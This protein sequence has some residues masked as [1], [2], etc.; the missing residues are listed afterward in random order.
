MKKQLEQLKKLS[1]ELDA[2]NWQ[3]KAKIE[4]FHKLAYAVNV[5]LEDYLNQ[6]AAVGLLSVYAW[7]GENRFVGFEADNA[8]LNGVGLQIDCKLDVASV[9]H[10]KPRGIKLPGLKDAPAEN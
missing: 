10:P 3:D 8:S 1:A 7:Q 6:I 4:A 2:G 9:S 5:Q